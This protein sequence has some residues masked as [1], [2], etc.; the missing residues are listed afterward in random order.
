L[1]TLSLDPAALAHS[2][3]PLRRFADIRIV[4]QNGAQVPYLLES[5]QAR[6]TLEIP[7][8]KTVPRVPDLAARGGGAHSFY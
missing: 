8:T 2:Q 1:V 3:G 4:D 7:V 5:R 6:L